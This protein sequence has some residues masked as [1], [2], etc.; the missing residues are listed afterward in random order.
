MTWCMNKQDNSKAKTSG[1]QT[2][3]EDAFKN[4]DKTTKFLFQNVLKTRFKKEK[5]QIEVEQLFSKTFGISRPLY[6][7]V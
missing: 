7:G 1:L 4:V 5:T 3:Q 6:S 2:R